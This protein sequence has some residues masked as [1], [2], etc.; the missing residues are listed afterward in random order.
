MELETKSCSRLKLCTAL[1]IPTI[2]CTRISE[3]CYVDVYRSGSNTRS[4]RL[5]ADMRTNMIKTSLDETDDGEH[6]KVV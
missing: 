5:P 6:K 1:N 2:L 4:E 3:P